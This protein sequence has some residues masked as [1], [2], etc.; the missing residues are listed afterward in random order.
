MRARAKLLAGD[1][2]GGDGIDV[3]IAPPISAP[4]SRRSN[5]SGRADG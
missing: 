3:L 5:S 1:D 2:A 4:T